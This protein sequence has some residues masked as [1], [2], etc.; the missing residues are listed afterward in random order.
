MINPY[1]V[2]GIKQNATK[3]DIIK[4]KMLAMR[5]RVY[6]MEEIS[7]AEKTLLKPAKRLAADFMFPMKVRAKRL[8]QLEFNIQ[9]EYV[10]LKQLDKEAFNSL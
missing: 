5:A 6:K 3:K 7:L 2:L 10:K 4:A 9:R 8:H 1:A